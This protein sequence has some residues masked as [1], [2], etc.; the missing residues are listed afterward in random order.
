MV[1]QNAAHHSI[2]A[3]RPPPVT[4]FLTAAA[5]GVSGMS[6]SSRRFLI[7]PFD[8][9]GDV[10]RFSRMHLLYYEMPTYCQ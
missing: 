7:D 3:A 4:F 1:D 2:R 10:A 8:D 6:G 9:L 5:A